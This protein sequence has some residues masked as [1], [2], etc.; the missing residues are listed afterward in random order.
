MPK[1]ERPLPLNERPK[2]R[3]LPPELATE[4]PAEVPRRIHILGTGSIGRLVAHSLRDLPDPPPVTLIF[5]G[6]RH[7][8][9]WQESRKE[10]TIRTD[11]IRVAR[12]GFDA[13]CQPVGFRRHGKRVSKQEFNEGYG[14]LEPGEDMHELMAKKAEPQDDGLFAPEGSVSDDPIYN[15]IVSV[16]AGTTVSALQS[17]ARRL[18]PQSTILFLQNGMGQIDEVNEHVFP[19]PTTRPKYLSGIITHGA[20]AHPNMEATHAGFGTIAIGRPPSKIKREKPPQQT[21]EAVPVEQETALD[22]TSAGSRYLLRTICRSPALAAVPNSPTQLLQAQLDKLAMNAIINP[23]TSLM[24]TRNGAIL[25]NFALS[26]AMRLLLGEIS[27]V[28]RNLPEL[29]HLPNVATRFAPDRLETLVVAM[30][31]RSKNNISSMLADVRAGTPTE[32][33]YINGYI[34]KRGEELGITCYMNYLV[35]QLIRGKQQLISM[36]NQDSFPTA[37]SVDSKAQKQDL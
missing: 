33:Q 34:V 35:V 2:E 20:H 10:I 6:S 12:D 37:G 18:G 23:L 31:Y 1:G 7:Y 29:A 14:Q 22:G 17:V 15:L 36:E 13:E 25:Y 26:R 27:L 28:I 8:R 5:H 3:Q 21:G 24:D 9:A 32:I 16:K 30:A 11:G 19:D 4:A